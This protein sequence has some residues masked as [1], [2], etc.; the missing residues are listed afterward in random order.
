MDVNL[1]DIERA[2]LKAIHRKA[3]ARQRDRIKAILMLDRGYTFQETAEVLLVDDMTIRRWLVLY[4]TETL[5]HFLTYHY[6]GSDGK[7]SAD[8]LLALD[9]H[10]EDKVYLTAK[11]ICAYVKDHYGRDYSEKGMTALLHRLGYSYHKPKPVPGKASL[12]VQKAFIAEYKQLKEGLAEQDQIY[13]MDAVHPMHNSQPACGWM[14]RDFEYTIQTNT[15]RQRVNING[16]YN[17]ADHSV[18]I[19]ESEMINSQST[20]LLFEK[21]EQKQPQGIIYIILDNARY[22]KSE[23]IRQYL[24]EH[25]RIQLKFLPPYCPNLNIIERLWRFFR[26]KITYNKYYDRFS[27]FK[28]VCLEFFDKIE[29]F[30]NE[31]MTLMTDN[32]QLISQ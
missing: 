18:V 15:G 13:F 29:Q 5:G 17:L 6:Q 9:A 8:Q 1:D 10:L 32:F 2:Q 27:F 31:L 22:Y 30:R 4:R 3:D 28:R 19:E 11:E 25:P 21:L 26:K 20:L 23:I 14:K 12:E 7:L 16:A 24:E